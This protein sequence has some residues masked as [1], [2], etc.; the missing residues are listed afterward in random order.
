MTMRLRR[1]LIGMAIAPSAPALAFLFIRVLAGTRT[2]LTLI[3][4]FK[5]EAVFLVVGY[6]V[7]LPLGFLVYIVVRQRRWTTWVDYMLAGLVMGIITGPVVVPIIAGLRTG[8][9]VAALNS[10]AN[11]P[12]GSFS[13]IFGIFVG[14]PVGLLFWLMARP[15]RHR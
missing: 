8:S 12:V 11:G 5:I 6:A 2:G 13:T 7:A 4:F 14:M 3:G 9:L 1:T 10:L 15:D